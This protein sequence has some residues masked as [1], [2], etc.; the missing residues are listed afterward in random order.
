[1]IKKHLL[2]LPI[3]GFAGATFAQSSVSVFGVADVTLS[4]GSGSISGITRLT[5]GGL[6]SNRIGFRGVEDLGGGLSAQFWLEAGYN[7]DDGSGQA[8][9]S[10]NQT[11]GASAT[12]FNFNRRSTLALA[13]TGWGEVRLGRDLVPQYSNHA[14]GDPFG[15]VGV[16]SAINFTGNISGVTAVRASNM[17]SYFTPGGLGGFGMQLSHYRGENA[18]GVANPDDGNGSGVRGTYTNGPLSLGLGLGK[19]E[20]LAGDATKRNVYAAYDFGTARLMGMYNSDK[21]GS[22]SARGFVIGTTVPVGAGEIKAA[23]SSNQTDAA[24]DPKSK[25]IAFG[26][27]HNLSKRTAV[28]G[29][30]ARVS[31]SG[32]AASSLNG[33]VTAPNASSS[34]F[35]FGLRHSF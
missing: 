5:G 21:T 32:G 29:T 6:T 28:Y 1:M 19:T 15:N 18:S 8:T 13:G 3:I 12:G 4:K 26:Y 20:Y 24:G 25:K 7:L 35:D 11:T 2:I 22:L 23:F 31:N 30:Y 9:N 16:G 27:V 17:I 33:A 10:N 34:G 14:S